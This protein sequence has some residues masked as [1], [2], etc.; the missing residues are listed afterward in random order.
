MWT[1]GWTC[2]GTG[3]HVKPVRKVLR[4]AALLTAIGAG[5]LRAFVDGQDSVGHA[6][7]SNS[8]SPGLAK[9]MAA[10]P[11][12]YD[13]ARK[14]C[15]AP[16]RSVWIST[17]DLAGGS[18]LLTSA[19]FW[20][21][22]AGVIAAVLTAAATVWVTL[23]AA[24]P[25]RQLLYDM[26]V[27]TPLLNSRPDPL[28]QQLKVSYG[29]TELKFPHSVNVELTS[30]ARRDITREAFDGGEPLRLDVGVPIV[31]CLD[32]K[33]TPA[34]QPEPSWTIDGSKLLIGPS[35]IGK[36]QT[37]VFSLLVDG[38][39][40]RLSPPKKTLIDV[41][42][43]PFDRASGRLSRF[44]VRLGL[45]VIVLLLIGFISPAT[46]GAL[47]SGVISGAGIGWIIAI[48][49]LVFGLGRGQAQRRR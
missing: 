45:V 11:P 28:P 18:H 13:S 12:G 33:T 6:A 38:P 9:V 41:D 7:L 4:A 37:I 23:R 42:I 19:V 14:A 3:T 1:P 31:E 2:N 43:R 20:G 10:Y 46:A 26:P 44:V 36:R 17:V 47:V 25:K 15:S 34:D 5:N 21:P 32:V 48:G 40:P 24:N 27:V 49:V 22:A 8:V 30:R 39:S 35:H 29:T 16:A